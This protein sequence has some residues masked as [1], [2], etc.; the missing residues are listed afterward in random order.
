MPLEFEGS[1]PRWFPV[2]QAFLDWLG[3]ACSG[4]RGECRPGSGDRWLQRARRRIEEGSFTLP[5]TTDPL[6]Q[7]ERFEQLHRQP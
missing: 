4:V 6:R 2:L 3:Q 7:I 1:D 5:P